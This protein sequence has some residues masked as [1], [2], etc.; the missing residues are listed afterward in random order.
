MFAQS[1]LTLDRLRFD[2]RALWYLDLRLNAL[3][4][5]Q[6]GSD[7]KT[8]VVEMMLDNT[9]A[10][11]KIARFINAFNQELVPMFARMDSIDLRYP[12]GFA[13]NWKEGAGVHTFGG[14]NG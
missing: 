8:H 1:G 6:P 9:R 4:V 14:G 7:D 10:D 3:A 11:Y 13:V 5:E 2:E 12:N